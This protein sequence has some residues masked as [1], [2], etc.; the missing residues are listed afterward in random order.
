MVINEMTATEC[1]AFLASASFGRLVALSLDNQPYVLPIYF[2]YEP[3]YIYV[4]SQ[5]SDR[6]RNGCGQIPKSVS[7]LRKSRT[8][9][10]GQASL[11]MAATRNCPSPNISASGNMR[12][13]C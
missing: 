8:S 11:P 10:S 2:A 9:R 7:K 4:L 13:S 3:G 12:G 6:K 5:C 1:G